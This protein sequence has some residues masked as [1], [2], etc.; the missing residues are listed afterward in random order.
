MPGRQLARR[1]PAIL[2]VASILSSI[3]PSVE[4]S[5]IAVHREMT[6]D[7]L[8]GMGWSSW[9]AIDLATRF[10]ESTDFGRLSDVPRTAVHIAAPSFGQHFPLLRDLAE[11]A[12]FSPEGS[13]GFHFNSLYTFDDIDRRWDEFGTWV[14]TVADW[15]N[16]QPAEG[17]NPVMGL[18]LVGLVSHAVQDFY[19]HSNWVEILDEF[20]PGDLDPDELP[21]WAELVHDADGWRE[22]HPE[23]DSE[24]ALQR[25]RESDHVCSE[26]DE[27]GGLQTGRVR[28]EEI[29]TTCDPWMHRHKV[30]RTQDTLHELAERETIIWVERIESRLDIPLRSYTPI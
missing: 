25:L 29:T 12:P 3:T 26:T 9:E 8:R 13:V 21:L 1:L 18:C 6:I 4:G 24:A 14:D 27:V 7:V 2:L 15:M 19:C 16:T 22:R 20:T 23:F 30:G 11:T 10:N 17:Q 5:E 28:G